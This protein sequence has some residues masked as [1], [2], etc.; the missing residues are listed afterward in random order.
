MYNLFILRK[1][2]RILKKYSDSY[3][4]KDLNNVD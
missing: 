1:V 4:G 2:N 3:L